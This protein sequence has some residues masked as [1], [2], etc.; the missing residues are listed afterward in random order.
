MGEFMEEF[1]AVIFKLDSEEYGVDINRVLSIEKEQ[2]IVPVPNTAS[3]IKGIINL[4]GEV[5]PVYS[6]RDKF[7]RP[8]KNSDDQQY[9]IVSING[10]SMALEV[11]GVD[12]IH[13]IEEDD[14]FDAPPIILN[15]HTGF[16]DKVLK[17]DKKLVII[18]NID[19]LL[20]KDELSKVE[21]LINND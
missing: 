9:I 4:R 6:L 18:M 17:N 14:I 20:S 12:K 13:N 11:D 3:Y 19:K 10:V 5:I 15:E 16:V 21:K 1:K 8:E 7:K 2:E